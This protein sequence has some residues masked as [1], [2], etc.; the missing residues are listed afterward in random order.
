MAWN[1]GDLLYGVGT[2]PL[3]SQLADRFREGIAT[4]EFSEGDDLPSESQL[5]ARFSISRATA[6]NA[7]NQLATEGLVSRRS[8]RGTSVLPRPVE[9]PLNLLSSFSEDMGRRG[10]VAEYK[11][12]VFTVEAAASHVA[13]ALDI[14]AGSE[15]IQIERLLVASGMAMAHSASWLAPSFAH[16]RDLAEVRQLASGPLYAWLKA[17]RSVVI[18]HGTEVIEAKVAGPELAKQLGIVPGAA[19]LHASRT[20]RTEPGN[21]VEYVERQYRA[22]RYRYRVELIRP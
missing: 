16:P 9:Q 2:L 7:L 8:G 21:P 12:T 14:E 15:V 17:S 20:A 1:D 19:V 4:G 11:N 22:D 13:I 5:V 18:T 3:W 6:R 10:L